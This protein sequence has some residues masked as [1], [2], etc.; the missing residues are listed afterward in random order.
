M[1]RR[2]IKYFLFLAFFSCL[3]GF[4]GQGQVQALTDDERNNVTIYQKASPSVVNVI[5]TVITRD[6]F[7]NAIPRE[8]SGSGSIVDARGHVLTNNH[9]IRDAKKLEVTLADS[10]KWPAKLVGTD[11]DNDLAVIKI[12]APA[13]KLKPLPLGDSQKLQVGQKVLAIGNPFGLGLTLTTGIISSLGR[14]IRSEVGTMIEDLIQTDA[15]INPGNSGGPLLNSEGE[16]I[17]INTAIISPTGA[18]VGIGFAIPVN[19]AKRI[20]PQLIAKGYVIYPWAGASVQPLF[21]ELAQVLKLKVER[22]A[23]V[24]EVTQGGPAEKAGLR[25]GNRQIQVGNVVIIVGGDVITR[26]DQ[27]EVKDADDLIKHIRERKPGEV[28]ILKVLR[29]GQFKEVKITL[30]ERPRATGR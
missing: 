7:L 28:V 30:Q 5:S 25:G 23:M 11:P 14:N 21:P 9:V 13:D 27:S 18:S 1:L 10:S 24:I 3:T 8:G 2:R 29:D 26:I 19:T 4:C 20:I 16:I 6:F 12:D 15:S 22:G 17:G